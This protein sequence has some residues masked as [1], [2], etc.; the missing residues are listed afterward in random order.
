[1]TL[2]VRIFLNCSFLIYFVFYAVFPLSAAGLSKESRDA[3]AIGEENHC[4]TLFIIDMALW[5]I[6]KSGKLFDDTGGDKFVV[7]KT[8]CRN[9]PEEM[10][11]GI[12]SNID[13]LP[14]CFYNVISQGLEN[15]ASSYI[16]I[17]LLSSGLSPPSA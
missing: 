13:L 5:K 4:S 16:N 14:L 3:I 15:Q 7:K 2:K 12:V 11:C 17:F 10:K 1:M 6:L 9:F 8:G